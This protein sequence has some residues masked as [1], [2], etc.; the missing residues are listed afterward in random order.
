[1]K[2]Q[3]MINIILWTLLTL[4]FYRACAMQDFIGIAI[5]VTVGVL[6]IWR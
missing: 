4:S 2:H 3:M 6:L 1:M 5:L